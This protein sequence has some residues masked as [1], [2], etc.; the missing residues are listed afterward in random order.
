[1]YLHNLILELGQEEVNNLILLDGQAVQVDLL[2]AGDLSGLDETTELGDGLPFLLLALGSTASTTSTATATITART[3]ASTGTSTGSVSHIRIRKLG[4]GRAT[5]TASK[6]GRACVEK[7]DWLFV[8]SD[9]F[10]AKFACFA[11]GLAVAWG[12]GSLRKLGLSESD[13]GNPTPRPQALSA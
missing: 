13:R 7:V 6:G 11:F 3:K 10:A 4:D 9:L 1:M 2:N 5:G 12:G 8:V